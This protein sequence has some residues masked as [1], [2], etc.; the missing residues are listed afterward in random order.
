M[1]IRKRTAALVVGS[2]DLKGDGPP[3]IWRQGFKPLA[4]GTRP[5][6][7]QDVIGSDV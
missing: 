6:E 7:Q 5:L 2:E 3:A 4:T 1:I